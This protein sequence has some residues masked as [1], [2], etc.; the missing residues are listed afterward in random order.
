[1]V[2]REAHLWVDPGAVK[3]RAVAGSAE[4]RRPKTIVYFDSAGFVA[5]AGKNAG[6]AL[7][8]LR[9]ALRQRFERLRPNPLSPEWPVAIG[10]VEAHTIPSSTPSALGRRV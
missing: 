1:S 4:G 8:R 10:W 6:A 2:A 3:V 9:T 7:T 5:L